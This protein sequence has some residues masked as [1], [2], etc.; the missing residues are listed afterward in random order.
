M[1]VCVSVKQV[2]WPIPQH[3]APPPAV[4]LGAHRLLLYYLNLITCAYTTHSFELI[5]ISCQWCT[6]GTSTRV[7]WGGHMGFRT[8]VSVSCSMRR[9]NTVQH[10]PLHLYPL[11]LP[12]PLS[13]PHGRGTAHPLV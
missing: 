1:C 12:A 11:T 8:D 7:R 2:S 9:P 3:G 4:Y 5:G 10:L 6:C 13:H